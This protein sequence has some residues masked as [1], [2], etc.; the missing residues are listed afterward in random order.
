LSTRPRSS[1]ISRA[2]ISTGRNETLAHQPSVTPTG[3]AGDLPISRQAVAK[4]LAA[5]TD[6]GLVT[7]VR[8]GREVRYELHP[9]P[10]AEVASWLGAVGVEWDGRL[11]RLQDLLT[12]RSS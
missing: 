7:R 8:A 4:H 12:R 3:L 6:A 9:E 2:W 11:G 5:L 10:L 1:R